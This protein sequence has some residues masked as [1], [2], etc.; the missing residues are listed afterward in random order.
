VKNVLDW[1]KKR[2]LILVLS[3]VAVAALPTAL[4]FSTA[5]T[6]KL[7]DEVQKKTDEDYK[8]LTAFN[9]DYRLVAISGEP[10]LQQKIPVN[11][12]ST[13]LY[14]ELASKIDS[15]AKK[16]VEQGETFNKA[17][18]KL[19]I[20]GLFPAPS[21]LERDS[22]LVEFLDVYANKFHQAILARIG[23]G[24]P[25]KAI[26]TAQAIAL[27]DQEFRNRVQN[28]R[29]GDQLSD[30]ERTRLTAELLSIRIDRARQAARAISVYADPSVF[31]GVAQTDLNARPSLAQAWDMQERAWLHSDV[32]RAV[33][34]VNKSEQSVPEGGVATSVVKR[35]V[36][37]APDKS[38]YDL[39]PQAYDPGVD[40]PPLNFNRS[41]TGRVSGPGSQNKWFDAREVE[42]DVIV[43]SKRLPAFID[44]LAETNFISVVDLD[45]TAVDVF[46]E[47]KQGYYYGDEN[48]VRATLRLEAIFLRSWRVGSM[49]DPVK[50]ALA[51][52]EGVTGPGGDAA[53]VAPRG[54]RNPTPP[55]SGGRRRGEPP[56]GEGG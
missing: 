26:D 27:H 19:L 41:L 8:A 37:V 24:T 6:K 18:H 16:L 31:A 17:D 2:W 35:I 10:I 43:A 47:I 42:V 5:M 23:A 11:S 49:P 50:K 13:R 33:A 7:V 28:E 15:E 9:N 22:K 44:A 34:K 1:L 39:D 52:V 32:V 21:D 45:I 46:E 3:I 20:D 38:G 25:P 56:P 40:K 54:P 29:G 30:E 48:V 12:A 36:R 14:R 51:M 55:P 53:P 4:Y